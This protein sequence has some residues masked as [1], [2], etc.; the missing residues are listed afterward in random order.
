MVPYTFNSS[1][2]EEEEVCISPWVQGQ[3]GLQSEIPSQ[4]RENEGW[5]GGGG[6]EKKK[7]EGRTSWKPTRSSYRTELLTNLL[8]VFWSNAVRGKQIW[9]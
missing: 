1:T 8:D 2:K 5:G 4:E 9:K 6:K 7:R 3:P